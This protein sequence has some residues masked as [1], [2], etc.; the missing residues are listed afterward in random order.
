MWLIYPY[1][2]ITIS[3]FGGLFSQ[4]AANL[5]YLSISQRPVQD[6]MPDYNLTSLLC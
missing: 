6:L 2:Q 1:W 5:E 3:A 4:I